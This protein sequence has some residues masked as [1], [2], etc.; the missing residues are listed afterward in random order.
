MIFISS[1]PSS[2]EWPDGFALELPDPLAAKPVPTTE[3]GGT[4]TTQAGAP[5]KFNQ[6][7]PRNLGIVAAGPG[8]HGL[9]IERAQAQARPR[10]KASE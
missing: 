4:A 8:L 3:A 7:Q 2:P 6:R 1:C 10:A 5:L 9:L